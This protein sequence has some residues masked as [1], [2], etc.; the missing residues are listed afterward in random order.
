MRPTAPWRSWRRRCCS[1][2][3]WRMIQLLALLAPSM[4]CSVDLAEQLREQR[5]AFER[6]GFL[7]L[8]GFA[9]P[10]EVA[11]LRARMGALVDDWQPPQ[12][13]ELLATISLRR[14]AATTCAAGAG[15]AECAADLSSQAPN[16]SFLLG[17]ASTLQFFPEPRAVDV[18]AMRLAPG[19]PNRLA[20]RKVGHALHLV[21]PLF[22]DFVSSGRLANISR[23]LGW[24]DP[25]VVQSA[26]RLAPPHHAGVE[27]HQDATFLHTEPESCLGLL[28]FLERAD[29]AN[30]CLHVRPG[31]HREPLRERL[32][33]RRHG[34]GEDADAVGLD[35]VRL[36]GGSDAEAGAAEQDDFDRSAFVAVP[37]EAGDLLVTHGTLD[38]FSG[39]GTDAD[40]SRE[41]FQV[42]VVEGSARWSP[43]NWL[44]YPEGMRFMSLK[45]K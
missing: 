3:A 1:T 16:H 43:D 23:D 5:L 22:R 12:G 34:E 19:V 36:A 17:S 6:D 37:M 20:V 42:H 44:Q 14:Q 31:S 13:E 45:F 39:P 18:A 28:L 40:R 15:S 4:G 29:E 27:R 9:S 30:G 41:T 10:S 8:R 32:V 11:A 24:H 7:L 25:V 38:H 21:E 26:Y 33:R 35:F 2:A